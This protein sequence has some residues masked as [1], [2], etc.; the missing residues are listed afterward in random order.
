MRSSLLV[1]TLAATLGL[2]ST[3][4]FAD[5]TL[6][7]AA[8][9]HRDSSFSLQGFGSAVVL[10]GVAPMAGVELGYRM[11]RSF[12]LELDYSRM[13]FDDRDALGALG[14]GVR[15]LAVHGDAATFLYGGVAV[16]TVGDNP[17]AEMPILRTG[18]GAEWTGKNGVFVSGQLGVNLIAIDGGVYPVPEARLGLG[19]RF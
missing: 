4:A 12:E 7:V 15:W 1:A 5:E 17:L 2:G 8:P 13:A 9:A 6:G 3:V 11:N 14:A 16:P 10:D 18:F 19:V